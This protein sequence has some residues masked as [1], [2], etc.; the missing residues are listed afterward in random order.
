MTEI[1]RMS[2]N[3]QLPEM[4][5]EELDALIQS[6]H[7]DYFEAFPYLR[8]ALTKLEEARRAMRTYPHGIEVG[9]ELAKRSGVHTGEIF[10]VVSIAPDSFTVKNRTSGWKATYT[11]PDLFAKI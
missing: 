2:L 3:S 6:V 1:P 7:S 10:D 11:N 5:R 4:T 9:D 8:T